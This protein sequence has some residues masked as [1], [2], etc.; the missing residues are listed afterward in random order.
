MGSSRYAQ[1]APFSI[2]TLATHP[3]IQACFLSIWCASAY[4]QAATGPCSS[5]LPFLSL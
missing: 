5:A 4:T 3:S 2:P 1:W